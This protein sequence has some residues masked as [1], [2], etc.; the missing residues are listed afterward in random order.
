MENPHIITDA[1]E[2]EL[3]SVRSHA[4][5]FT[6]HRKIR[7]DALAHITDAAEEEI[8]KLAYEGFDV[9][10]CGGACGFD[11]F[12]ANAA[13]RVKKEFPALRLVMVLPC[14]DQTKGWTD[15]DRRLHD[16]ICAR[17][18]VVCISTAY[19]DRCMKKRNLFLVDH[20]S[21]GIA[22][23]TGAFRTGTGQTVRYAEK[24]GIPVINLAD[25]FGGPKEN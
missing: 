18:E 19:D 12:A 13:L 4:C 25:R 14:P 11:L 23:Y 8:R 7:T 24:Q 6:G 15:T 3:L 10:L 9:F 16:A 2:W 1:E 5:F 21:V 22:Y 20:A 17:G